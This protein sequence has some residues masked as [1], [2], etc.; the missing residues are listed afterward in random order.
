MWSKLTAM[1]VLSKVKDWVLYGSNASLREYELVCIEA[2]RTSLSHE[3]ATIL[4]YQLKYLT[5]L[6]RL[7]RDKLLSFHANKGATLPAEFTF[8]NNGAEVV[9]ALVDLRAD[10]RHSQTSA[11]IVLANGRLSSL[12]FRAEPSSVGLI[13]RG[14]V[15]V[16]RIKMIADPMVTGTEGNVDASLR[17]EWHGCLL[18]LSE[19]AK[20]E[21]YLPP[22]DDSEVRT[23][24]EVHSSLPEDYIEIIRQSNGLRAGR[25]KVLGASQLRTVVLPEHDLCVLAE[26]DGGDAVCVDETYTP[27]RLVFLK[28]DYPVAVN[29]S[30]C[31]ALLD[32]VRDQD[33]G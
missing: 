7:S 8:P 1:G 10:E 9:V 33:I 14:S 2:W 4:D 25:V 26:I 15:E 18:R 6:Q 27:A 16:I 31:G 21:A 32:A 19:S 28:D 12:E 24:L 29:Q 5:F 30:F 22:A 20:I 11:R 3:A 23:A 17:T 13:K